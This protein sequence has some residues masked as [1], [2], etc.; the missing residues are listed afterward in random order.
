[1]LRR[2]I[3][4]GRIVVTAAEKGKASLRTLFRADRVTGG[5]AAAGANAED[6]PQPHSRS[7][8]PLFDQHQYHKACKKHRRAQRS[9]TIAFVR[10]DQKL[11]GHQVEQCHQAK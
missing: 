8:Q 3:A 9:V 4:P 7:S 11:F 1:M 2:M 5:E 10:L 6:C